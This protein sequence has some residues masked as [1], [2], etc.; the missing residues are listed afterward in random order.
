MLEKK[1]TFCRI[2]EASCGLIASV[3]DGRVVRTLE[4]PV[5]LENLAPRAL[6]PPPLGSNPVDRF[7]FESQRGFCEHYASAFTV[8]RLRWLSTP[9]V[10]ATCSLASRRVARRSPTRRTR[11]SRSSG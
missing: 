10:T 9:R 1:H 7:L 5:R 11:C 3:E 2:C 8:M 6:E 4:L